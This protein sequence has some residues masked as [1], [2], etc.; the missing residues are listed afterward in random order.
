MV[1]VDGDGDGVRSADLDAGVDRIISEPRA[2]ESAHPG[3]RPGLAEGVPPL[4]GGRP[5]RSALPMAP[6]GIL[7][8][9]PTGSLSTGTV[10]LCHHRREC[11]AV[12]VYGPGGRI[13]GWQFRAGEWVRRW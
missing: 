11:F 3:V 6:S 12:R 4:G 2:I 7:A 8:A 1:A 9:S 10:Y 5:P 13:G